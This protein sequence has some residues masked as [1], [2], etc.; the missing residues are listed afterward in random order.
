MY[1]SSVHLP[2]MSSSTHRYFALYKPQN[3]LSQF[4]GKE[5]GPFLGDLGFDFPEGSHAIGRL[6]KNSEGLLLVCTNRAVTKLLFQSKEPHRRTYVVQV[7]YHMNE[8]TLQQLR[9][10]VSISAENNSEWLTS[11][12][13]AD[14]IPKPDPLPPAEEELAEFIPHTWLRMT[15][16][17]GRFHQVRKMVHA[18]RH[19]CCRL[20]RVSIEDLTLDSL[21]P[22]EVREMAEEDFFRLLKL[23]S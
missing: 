15:L 4:V 8:D 23:T 19:K 10:G 20:I 21:K 13:E 2:G 6:D 18:L 14:I 3:M 5:E 22:G 7:R 12:C 1:Y 11:P 16:T 17:E 9:N